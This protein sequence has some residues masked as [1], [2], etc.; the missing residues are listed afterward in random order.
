MLS[1]LLTH[2]YLN[3]FIQQIFIEPEIVLDTKTNTVPFSW[4][5]QLS[6]RD[7]EVIR[8]LQHKVGGAL[9]GFGEHRRGAPLA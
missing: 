6:G 3:S 4:S 1:Q 7:R 9:R 8:E 5:S 2:S